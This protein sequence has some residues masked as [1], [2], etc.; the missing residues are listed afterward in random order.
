MDNKE[1]EYDLRGKT[2]EETVNA[3]YEMA[4]DM[5]VQR[6]IWENTHNYEVAKEM[7][8]KYLQEKEKEKEKGV[9]K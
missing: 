1:N 8:E 6:M 9:K 7:Y 2:A 3:F 4:D 5:K